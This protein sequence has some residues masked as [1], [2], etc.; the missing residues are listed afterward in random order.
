L[1]FRYSL[2]LFLKCLLVSCLILFRLSPF[3]WL[4]S[5][6]HYN[7]ECIYNVSE[8]SLFC[9]NSYWP[10]TSW[11]EILILSLNSSKAL[12]L[13]ANLNFPKIQNSLGL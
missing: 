12:H 1:T 6:N 9:F 8:L 3:I 2:R 10:R 7:L 11:A 4:W 13:S 5:N